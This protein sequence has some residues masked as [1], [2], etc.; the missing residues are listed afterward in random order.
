VLSS[1]RAPGGT[2]LPGGASSSGA[3]ALTRAFGDADLDELGERAAAYDETTVLAYPLVQRGERFPFAAPA[4]QPFVV[5][6]PA[7]EAERFAA[8]LQ[9]VA[10]VERLCFDLLDRLGAPTGGALTLTGGA[11]RSR[12]WCQLRADVLG[13]P[14][15]LVEQSEAAFG[16]AVLAAASSGGGDL[17]GAATAMVGTREVIEPRPERAARLLDNYV[18]FLSELERRDWLKA[19]LGDHARAR[20]AA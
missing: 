15:R 13:R 7:D 5:G 4:A 18:R 14:V 12:R 8:L 3:G 20:A 19:P 17:A 1:H 16:M 11:T 9:G 2:W 6:E 10:F